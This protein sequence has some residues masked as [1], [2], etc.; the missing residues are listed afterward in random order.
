MIQTPTK[1]SSSQDS[2]YS[3]Q[4]IHRMLKDKGARLTPQ[5]EYIL[6]VFFKNE[7]GF[8]LSVE[9]IHKILTKKNKLNVSLA[10]VYRTVKTLYLM[11]ILREVDL[12]EGHKHYELSSSEDEHHHH[13]VCMNCNKTIEF[14]NEEV[15]RL[16]KEIAKMHNVEVK[17]VE[18]KIFGNCTDL[19]DHSHHEH[20]R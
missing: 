10:T 11:G 1:K 18:L 19:Q 6:D 15:N 17:D 20:R 2:G 14:F 4:L 16:A 9:D 5:R 3:I 12:A 8:H 13:I 7:N